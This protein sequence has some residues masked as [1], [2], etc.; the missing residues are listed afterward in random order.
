[1][2][3][4]R[5]YR[6]QARAA[7]VE[8]TRRRILAAFFDLSAHRLLSDITLDAVAEEAGVSVQTVLRQFGSRSGLVEATADYARRLVAEERQAP[9]GDVAEAVRVLVDHYERRGDAVMLL[10][11]Q[12]QSDAAIKELTDQGR[13]LHR[14]WVDEAFAPWLDGETED[15]EALTDLLVVSTDLFTWK[16]LRRDRRLTR[17]QTERRMRTLVE[18]VLAG[19]GPRRETR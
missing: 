12:E 7:A 18:R 13:A 1:M 17:S 9:V 3:T 19:P 4:A 11:A 16:L 2:K 10:V 6:M 14:A 8:E 15:R 5:P